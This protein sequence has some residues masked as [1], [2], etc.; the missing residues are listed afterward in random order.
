MIL[1]S[2]LS[3]KSELYL[4]PPRFSSRTSIPFVPS[5]PF[6]SVPFFVGLTILLSDGILIIDFPYNSFSL[7]VC[8]A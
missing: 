2:D 4:P 5:R 8:L 1:S 6:T 3:G 7:P